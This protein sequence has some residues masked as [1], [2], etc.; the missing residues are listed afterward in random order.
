MLEFVQVPRQSGRTL[1][2]DLMK[3]ILMEAAAKAANKTVME[4]AA[5]EKEVTIE[6]SI[7][8]V[9]KERIKLERGM[10]FKRN[11][12]LYMIVQ[13]DD[14]LFTIVNLGN[15]NRYIQPTTMDAVKT[16]LIER[17]FMYNEGGQI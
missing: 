5:A 8:T 11:E 16:K 17:G 14:E 9:V 13:T 12:K 6:I 4:K 15:G 1:G 2:D 7:P 3:I 10:K